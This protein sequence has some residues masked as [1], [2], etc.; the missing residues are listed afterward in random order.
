VTLGLGH[1]GHV[2]KSIKAIKT[3]TDKINLNSAKS[4]SVYTCPTFGLQA[5]ETSRVEHLLARP[6]H[7][8]AARPEPTTDYKAEEA[9]AYLKRIQGI[10]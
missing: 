9:Q 2:K 8:P 4:R 1:N 10:H 5:T 7:R 6:L 3:V